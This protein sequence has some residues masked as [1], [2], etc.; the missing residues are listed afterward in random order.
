M[1][2]FWKIH[3]S[4]IEHIDLRE[5]NFPDSPI[6]INMGMMHGAVDNRTN[7]QVAHLNLVTYFISLVV[8]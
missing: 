3:C 5:T 2:Q 4:F 1:V 7:L 8:N 6:N